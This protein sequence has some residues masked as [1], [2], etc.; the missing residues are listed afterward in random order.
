MWRPTPELRYLVKEVQVTEDVGYRGPILQQ[1]FYWDHGTDV[2]VDPR[3]EKWVDV[4]TVE[5][6]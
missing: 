6:E 5:N 3:E 1:K 4:P 2:F